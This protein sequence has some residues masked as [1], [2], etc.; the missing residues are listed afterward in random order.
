MRGMSVWLGFVLG[1]MV[2]VSACFLGASFLW[3]H[4]ERA[5]DPPC[6]KERSEEK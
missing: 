5:T 1:F 3:K 6:V 4:F 2:G